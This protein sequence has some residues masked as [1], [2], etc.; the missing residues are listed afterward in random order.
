MQNVRKPPNKI[1]EIIRE[2]QINSKLESCA[3]TGARYSVLVTAESNGDYSFKRFDF[4]GEKE[5][6]WA[7]KFSSIKEKLHLFQ[8][9]TDFQVRRVYNNLAY[10]H[11]FHIKFAYGQ[12][13]FN[14]GTLSI[15]SI[16]DI[17]ALREELEKLDNLFE[18]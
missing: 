13:A 8:N 10:A 11:N 18:L 1:S 9:E 16:K 3:I 14:S 5:V 12:I 4:L 2:F 15:R 6:P 17:V 7:I